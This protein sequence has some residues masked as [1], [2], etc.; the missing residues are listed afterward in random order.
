MQLDPR[1]SPRLLILMVLALAAVVSG[2]GLLRPPASAQQAPA[3]SG[4]T[5]TFLAPDTPGPYP[6]QIQHVVGGK[7]IT[8]RV[9]LYLPPGYNQNKNRLPLVLYLHDQPQRGND[10]AVLADVGPEPRLR[11][12]QGQLQAMGM[13]L[14]SPQ[15]PADMTW[16]EPAISQTLLALLDRVGTEFR[17]DVER[18]SAIGEGMGADGVWAL[19]AAAPQR[20]ASIYAVSPLKDWTQHVNALRHLAIYGAASPE[21]VPAHSAL[22]KNVEAYKNHRGDL[23]FVQTGGPRAGCAEFVFSQPATYEW[24]RKQKRRTAEEKRQREAQWAKEDAAAMAALPKAPGQYKLAD[25]HWVGFQEVV[26]PYLLQLPEG[27]GKDQTRFP[28]MMFLCGAGERNNLNGMALHGPLKQLAADERLRRWFP[29]VFIA[30]VYGPSPE[31]IQACVR[32]L[33]HVVQ[34]YRVDPDRVYGT[35]IS[36]GGTG[37]WMLAQAAPD[38]FAAGAPFC[39]RAVT[40]EQV[41]Q[42]L[43]SVPTWMVVGTVDGDFTNAAP[44]MYNAMRKAGA[45]VQFT[46]VPGEGHF[47]FGRFYADQRFYEW[48]L[49]QRRPSAA[50]R[51]GPREFPA[52][53]PNSTVPLPPGERRGIIKGQGFDLHYALHLP[54]STGTLTLPPQLPGLL[55]LHDPVDS[56]TDMNWVFNYGPDSL[57]RMNDPAKRHLPL[58]GIVPQLPHG[59][60]WD[61]P[62]IT[63]AV[64]QA[65]DE[66]A[67]TGRLDP[68]RVLLGGH[69]Q[70]ATAAWLLFLAQPQRFAGFSGFQAALPAQERLGPA[71]R[72]KNAYLATVGNDGGVADQARQVAAALGKLN[73]SAELCLWPNPAQITHFP[74]Y[75]DPKFL[76]WAG[77]QKR[78]P[79]NNVAAK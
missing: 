35:G 33:D 13:I 1:R 70:G 42:R 77:Q 62:A 79:A 8:L 24:L 68:D 3:A 64:L 12:D 44:I 22:R 17:V 29:F 49:Q 61:E 28:V 16:D 15:C 47:L 65:V 39:G 36:F 21:D 26:T 51:A 30:P 55:Y 69:A 31:E 27:Y 67:K 78:R 20:L 41:G 25:R 53:A 14:L 76:A 73:G 52:V 34:T 4:P 43:R 10:P 9:R 66:A 60:R 19:A 74:Y 46:L 45:P 23:Q 37:T 58:V 7:T 11:R 63:A 5:L 59:R 72:F 48:L 57:A 50:E 56:A 75:T 38:R 71:H 32:I 18:V 54:T 2:W 6:C 40:P